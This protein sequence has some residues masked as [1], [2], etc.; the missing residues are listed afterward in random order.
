M[1]YRDIRRA[2]LEQGWRVEERKAADIWF[3]PDGATIVTWHRTPSDVRALRNFLARM[4]HGGLRWPA[5]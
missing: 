3:S 4:R 1:D 2:A 5:T